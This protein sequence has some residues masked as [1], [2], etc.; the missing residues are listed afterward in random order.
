MNAFDYVEDDTPPKSSEL[1]NDDF[2]YKLGQKRGYHHIKQK[3]DLNCDF[4]VRE[5]VVWGART[6]L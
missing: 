3:S 4:V 2:Y 5:I 6:A 1:L